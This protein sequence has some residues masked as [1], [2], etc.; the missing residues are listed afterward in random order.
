[1]MNEFRILYIVSPDHSPASSE[2]SSPDQSQ[3]VTP[4]NTFPIT[5]AR[6]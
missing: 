6:M 4:A 1:M 2:N 5:E 3:H